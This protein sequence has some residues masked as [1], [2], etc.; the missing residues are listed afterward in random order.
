ME[1]K[2]DG[3]GE[4]GGGK[5]EREVRHRDHVLNMTDQETNIS[6]T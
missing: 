1:F 4:R 5:R 6:H 3:M 2:R